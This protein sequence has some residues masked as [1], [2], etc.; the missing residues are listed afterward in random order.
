M[1]VTLSFAG[2]SL[3][4][5]PVPE[6]AEPAVA[7]VA[8][9]VFATSSLIWLASRNPV[10]VEKMK[11][12]STVGIYLVI[13]VMGGSVSALV[14]RLMESHPPA[15]PDPIRVLDIG[16]AIDPDLEVGQQVQAAAVVHNTGESLQL[17]YVSELAILEP[18]NRSPEHLDT[19]AIQT[20]QGAAVKDVPFTRFLGLPPGGKVSLEFKTPPIRDASFVQSLHEDTAYVL[21]MAR[22]RYRGRSG[23]WD[24]ELCFY[25]SLNS[26]L[27]LCSQHNGPPVRAK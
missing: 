13:F 21:V 2:A 20:W 26:G 10:S 9:G 3:F 22:L 25:K 24:Q 7:A 6:S 12:T 18:M 16:I 17:A 8:W 5:A 27:N 4:G 11:R 14:Y 23:E 1:L 19:L 15:S